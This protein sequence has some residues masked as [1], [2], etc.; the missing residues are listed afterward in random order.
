MTDV[1][2]NV[3]LHWHRFRATEKTTLDGV[4]VYSGPF[5][6]MMVRNGLY[7]GNYEGPERELLL[8]H[9]R[10]GE[11][12]LEIGAGIGL[13]GLLAT[14]IAGAG[15]VLSY[16]ANPSL[17][18]IIRA[19]YAL[20][21][22]APELRMKAVTTDGAP[23][24]FHQCDNVISSSIYD[25]AEAARRIQVQS[26]ALSDVLAEWRPDLLV[27]DVEGYEVD[28]LANFPDRLRYL[29]IELHPHV[30]GE[31]RTE[32]L[33]SHLADGGFKVTERLLNNAFLSRR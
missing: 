4:T 3:R 18:P 1:F 11:R 20:N 15:N 19:N 25:R 10:K 24:T 9:L 32:A 23:V 14:R 8:R 2:R 5:Q 22:A 33:L 13:I 21:A 12:V 7:K 29:L 6:A 26:D 31:D 17:E 28:L 16:E 30:V 27:M